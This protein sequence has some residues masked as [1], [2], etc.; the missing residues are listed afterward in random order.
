MTSRT[1]FTLSLSLP[2]VVGALGYVFPWLEGMLFLLGV[3]AVPYAVTAAVLAV[4]IRRS[5]SLRGLVWLSVLAPLLF[6]IA[7][8]GFI[9]VVGRVPEMNLSLSEELNQIA[10]VIVV[11]A[12]YSVPFIAAAWGIWGVLKR[13][14][15]VTSGFTT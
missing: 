13:L 2:L 8:A 9:E 12:V 7:L 10:S 15:I 11:G 4:L 1:Y 3:A 6:G 14:G 5:A